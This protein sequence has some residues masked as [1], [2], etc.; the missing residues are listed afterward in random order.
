MLLIETFPIFLQYVAYLSIKCPEE[1][2]QL[3]KRALIN[4]E[5]S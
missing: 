2:Y 4:L 3:Q 5:H 1:T